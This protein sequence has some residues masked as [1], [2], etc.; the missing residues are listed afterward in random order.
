MVF[1]PHEIDAALEAAVAEPAPA[2]GLGR[3]FAEL[4][5]A[6]P[7][8]EA[9]VCGQDRRSFAEVDRRTNQLAAVLTE[10]GAAPGSA[11][12][13]VLPNRLEFYEVAIAAWKLGATVVPLN[14]RAPETERER[15]YS[16]AR[17]AVIV[18]D[19][20]EP[21]RTCAVV[22]DDLYTQAQGH[23]DT[24]PPDTPAVPWLA[25]GSGGSTG[26]P[27]L[28][29]KEEPGPV[30]PAKAAMLGMRP[31]GR[32]L[33]AGP[34]YHSGPFNWGVIHLMAAGGTIV[35]AEKF[36]AE[37]FLATIAAERI[38]WAMVVPTMLR[39]IMRLPAIVREG[40]DLTSLEVLLH[41]AAACP[42]TL[43][44][45]VLAFFGAERVWE[46]YGSTEI[47]LGLMRG[48]A[49]LAHP[50]SVGQLMA[51]YDVSIRDNQGGELPPGQVGEI[52]I[53][54]A[55]GATF[56]YRGA[57]ARA[58]SSGFH[59]VGDLGSLDADGY[60]YLSDRRTDLII[61]GGSNVYPAEVEHVLLDHPG[62]EDVAVIGLPDPEWGQ[63]VHALVAATA[64][65][66]P[67]SGEELAAHCRDRLMPYKAPKT[68]EFTSALPRDAAGKLRRS[69]LRDERL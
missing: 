36:D 69:R 42:P 55:G 38:T 13:V 26:A 18:V 32:Q 41:G 6:H 47:G 51:A 20:P 48:D 11:V 7:D 58:D 62:V 44:R 66:A 61:S 54:Q 46:V 3:R 49:W 22:L 23:A 30:H 12:A 8:R 67:P 1:S 64:P 35:L 21:S 60:L 68:Y 45:E 16:L 27:K 31:G 40:H 9:L 5:K 29:V 10:R 53:R 25:I 57:E 15:L 19:R 14:H 34:L 59:S 52:W 28:I 17:P 2:A 24:A 43:K 4:A 56:S 33:V 63:R 65:E 50:G 37:G 39:R